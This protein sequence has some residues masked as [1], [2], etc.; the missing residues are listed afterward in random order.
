[1]GPE[2]DRGTATNKPS[3]GDWIE[4]DDTAGGN[5]RRGQITEVLGAGRHL[6]YRVRWDEEHESLFYPD[7]QGGSIVHRTP[8]GKRRGR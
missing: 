3:A 5:P 6:H 2:T 8:A 7:P 4:V 1:M